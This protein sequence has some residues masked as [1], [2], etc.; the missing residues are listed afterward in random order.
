MHVS[1]FGKDI[2]HQHVHKYLDAIPCIA[3][4]TTLVPI[5]ATHMQVD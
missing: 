4:N 3:D 5:L 1:C 2:F